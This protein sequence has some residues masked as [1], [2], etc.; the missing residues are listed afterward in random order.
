MI[1]KD[2]INKLDTNIKIN[3]N[4]DTPLFKFSDHFNFNFNAFIE[5]SGENWFLKIFIPKTKNID[6]VKP[7]FPLFN[8]E[9]R[10]NYYIATE[11]I[12]NNDIINFIKKLD[13]IFGVD[14]NEFRLSGHNIEV[15]LITIENKKYEISNIIENEISKFHFINNIKMANRT[16]REILNERNSAESLY[17]IIFS[18]D[19]KTFIDNNVV[20]LL[21]NREALVQL[22]D[23]YPENDSFRV[24]IYTKEKLNEDDIDTVSIENNIYEI[25]IKSRFISAIS[26]KANSMYIFRD[27]TFL[28]IVK[29]KI[30]VTT[31]M[32]E[33]RSM[34]YLKIIYSVAMEFKREIKLEI[35]DKYTDNIFN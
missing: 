34:E 32:P 6:N 16:L 26:N 7:L 17:T 11:K 31:I 27:Y 21:A 33:F 14:I 13:S 29:E 22:K 23:N 8:V 1:L 18:V 30:V 24:F 20:K 19:L 9:E 3:L 10:L 15:S 35:F 28:N 12:N 2:I 5:M 4:M 25:Y